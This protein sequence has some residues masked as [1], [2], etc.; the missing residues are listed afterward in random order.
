MFICNCL[1]GF[2][3]TN[4]EIGMILQ[5]L[6]RKLFAFKYHIYLFLVEKSKFRGKHIA[7]EIFMAGYIMVQNKC[8]KNE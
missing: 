2:E 8:A 1:E 5:D 6:F 7:A 3:G 4:C